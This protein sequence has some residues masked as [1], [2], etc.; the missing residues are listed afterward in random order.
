[1]RLT[2]IF[3]TIFIILAIS[4]VCSAQD[5]GD[6]ENWLAEFGGEAGFYKQTTY[7]LVN[8]T[9]EDAADAKQ[10]L[11]SIKA[12]ATKDEWEGIYLGNTAIGDRN[13]IWN[14][15]GGFASRDA[16]NGLIPSERR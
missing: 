1:M 14:A 12:S 4:S 3:T 5:F 13:M 6:D 8:F 9:K 2:K 7:W 16:P 11:K 10:K 15:A